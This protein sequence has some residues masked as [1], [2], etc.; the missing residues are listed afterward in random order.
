MGEAL[1]FAV[2]DELSVIDESHA[3]G[4]GELLGAGADE[5]DVLALFEDEAR[6]LDGVAEA[7]DAGDAAGLHAA[8]IHEEGVELYAAIGGEEAAAAGVEG[9]IVFEDGDGGFDGV[10][11]GTAAGE[12]GVSGFKGGAD[13]GLVGL[14]GVGGDGPCTAMNEEGGIVRGWGGHGVHGSAFE[15]GLGTRVKARGSAVLDKWLKTRGKI[16]GGKLR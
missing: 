4:G 3:V 16:R 1:A 5:V 13:A 7:L 10:D 8:A 12:D 11:G 2:E 9:G 6:G 15:G 14:S